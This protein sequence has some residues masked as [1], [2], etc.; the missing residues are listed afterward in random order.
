[1]TDAILK[2]L[3]LEFPQY[4]EGYDPAPTLERSQQL[5]RVY[6]EDKDAFIRRACGLDGKPIDIHYLTALTTLIPMDDQY[7]STELVNTFISLVING[8]PGWELDIKVKAASR[9][10]FPKRSELPCQWEPPLVGIANSLANRSW[11]GPHSALDREIIVSLKANFEKII[12]AIG[13]NMREMLLFGYNANN[14]RMSVVNI[15]LVFVRY[16]DMRR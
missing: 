13:K 3:A 8:F 2:D 15:L 6:K 7:R 14:R 9:A 10:N 4:E 1:M 5:M 12:K 16:C 11:R